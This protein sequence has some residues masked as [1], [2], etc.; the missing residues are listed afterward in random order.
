MVSGLDEVV[1]KLPVAALPALIG[2][3]ERVKT[4]A[5]ARVMNERG[6]VTTQDDDVLTV[7]EV[8]QRLKIPR[9]RAY[10]LTRQGVLKTIRIG[11]SVRVA[12]KELN[13][14][15]AQRGH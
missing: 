1:L 3:L 5:L 15:L 10:Q 13:N 6:I 11:R 2:E 7:P 14:Y 8:A 12:T 4:Q 9:C